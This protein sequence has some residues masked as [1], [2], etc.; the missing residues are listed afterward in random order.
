VDAAEAD[1]QLAA[2]A[3]F[4][5]VGFGSAV[6][7]LLER[8]LSEPG[9]DRADAVRDLARALGAP[10]AAAALR[11]LVDRALGRPLATGVVL[12]ALEPSARCCEFDYVHPLAALEWRRLTT[13]AADAG[14]ELRLPSDERGEGW[15]QGSIDLIY[16]HQG[17][18]FVVDYKTNLLGLK[19][20]DYRPARIEQAMTEH[21]YH[22][23]WL[24]YLVALK[25]HLRQTLPEFDPERHLGG[26]HYLFLRGFG[27]EPGLGEYYLCPPPALIEAADRLLAGEGR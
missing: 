27:L 16:R 23:Q 7:R 13:L 8:C 14:I 9:V 24:M 10:P 18:Y 3:D 22:L 2:L 26:V 1:P 17:R 6:H 4:G 19:R 12:A 11:D 5:G 20:D 21:G 15:L 25:R